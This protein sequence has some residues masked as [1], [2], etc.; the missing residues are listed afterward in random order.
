MRGWNDLRA[1]K[2]TVVSHV[3]PMLTNYNVSNGFF[4]AMVTVGGPFVLD[5]LRRAY[6]HHRPGNKNALPHS[7]IHQDRKH[8]R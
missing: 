6:K 8:A 1:C 2:D 5:R 7:V 3:G 4:A